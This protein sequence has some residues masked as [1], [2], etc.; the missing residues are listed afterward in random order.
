MLKDFTS[1]F[2]PAIVLTLLFAAL[3]GLAYPAVLTGIGQVAF[4][5]QAN[6][7]LIRE[8][9]RVLGSELLAQGFTGARYFHPRPSA[10][11]AGYEADNSYGSNL[12]PASQALVDRVTADVAA[13]QQ[14][15]PGTQVPP[16]LVTTSASG[17][18]PHISP[19]AAFFQ[20][21]RV[22]QARGMPES[23]VR[24]LVE[25]RI[26]RPLLGFVGQPRVNVLMLNLALDQAVARRNKRV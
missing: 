10:A 5:Y 9:N 8:G 26:Q 16:D 15:S 21:T 22:A 17:R 14:Q 6:G 18:D 7:S 25:Q 3:L 12:G 23:E 1:A 19:E 4:P 24:A 11:G 2:R 20:I 13:R